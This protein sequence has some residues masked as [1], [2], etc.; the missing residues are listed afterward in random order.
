MNLYEIDQAILSLVDENGEVL[1][2]EAFED[3]QMQRERKIEGVGLWVK[4]LTSNAAEIREEEKALAERRK[5][6]EN[7]AKRL[8]DYLVLALAGE[9]FE[10]PRLRISYRKSETVEVKDVRD[11]A[12]EYVT[13]EA[14]EPNK[15]AI[16]AAI[17]AGIHVH[18]AELVEHQNIQIR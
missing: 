5:A 17:K 6:M 4:N 15:T 1:N 13:I 7:K 18:G 12:P 3:L 8:R 10:T 2:Y 16:K 9:R 14:P 11:L